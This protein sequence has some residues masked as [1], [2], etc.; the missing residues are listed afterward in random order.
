MQDSLLVALGQ[1]SNQLHD[2]KEFLLSHLKT[3][4]ADCYHIIAKAKSCEYKNNMLSY[5]I[6]QCMNAKFSVEGHLTILSDDSDDE[7]KKTKKREKG[8]IYPMMFDKKDKKSI[9]FLECDKLSC[10]LF[11]TDLNRISN[12]EGWL[13]SCQVEYIIFRY[14]Y[15]STGIYE[16]AVIRND[17]VDIA[18]F[19][20]TH[21]RLDEKSGRKFFF[22][23]DKMRLFLQT[24]CRVYDL[25]TKKIGV[26]MLNI[27]LDHFLTVCIVNIDVML[28]PTKQI[29][30]RNQ[31]F[32]FVM[33]SIKKSLMKKQDMQQNIRKAVIRYGHLCLV[34]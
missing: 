2:E 24:M 12:L 9:A 5:L 1:L 8:M 32:I 26:G 15:N 14:M 25:T 22:N 11:K 17:L 34:T 33:D 23:K 31:P 7:I 4:L 28:D 27:D 13:T 19:T 21:L 16:N 20:N 18:Y 6:E 3:T 30:G 29:E 10:E